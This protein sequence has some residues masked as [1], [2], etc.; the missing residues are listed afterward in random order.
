MA[1]R[2]GAI[3][4]ERVADQFAV[5]DRQAS[6]VSRYAVLVA[7]LTAAG[8]VFRLSDFSQGLFADELSTAWVLGGRSLGQ[9]L[10]VVHSNDEI[11]PPL[12]FVLA[13]LSSKLG[14]NPDLIRLPSLIAGTASIPLV[15]LVGART[16]GRAAGAVA[17][18]VFALSPFMIYYST[19]ARSYA[20]MIAL[21]LC[22]ILALL[23]AL[24]RDGLW[25]WVAFA[26]AAAAAMYSHYTAAFPLAAMGVWALVFHPGRRRNVL[27]A[28]VGAA[29]LFAPWIGG[30]LADARSPTTQI[31]SALSPF[32]F[33]WVRQ[34]IENWAIGFPYV[35]Q[36]SIPGTTAA[37]IALFGVVV[38]V[39]GLA[40]RLLADWR[41]R[42]PPLLAWVRGVPAGW[43]LIVMLAIATPL[44]EAIYSALGPNLLGARN[45]NASWPGLA[46]AIGAVLTAPGGVVSV[47]AIALTLAGFGIGTARTLQDRWARPD[48]QAAADY[49]NSHAGPG[50]VVVDDSA[51]TPVPLTG[52]DVYLHPGHP[53]VRLGLP[54]ETD[55]P[56][57]ILDPVP[58]L[59]DQVREA[60]AAARGHRMF[61]VSART[62]NLVQPIRY[63]FEGLG[64]KLRADLP[65]GYRI[66]RIR[67]YPGLMPLEMDVVYPPEKGAGH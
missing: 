44:G 66:R 30:Y 38:G 39:A 12:F 35:Q 28:G 59:G 60:T 62:P 17:A 32:T 43:A 4:N 10:T 1:S 7:G 54:E 2:E 9:V 20:L 40:G 57:A 5:N 61:V 36:A 65:A 16:V 19:E 13:W 23:A 55:R 67:S 8:L 56:F 27:I 21:V 52:L 18:A 34:S 46:L 63:G 49:I 26:V 45:L 14:S 22:A 47:V 58:R 24:E 15:Y 51:L 11:T 31:L 29:I 42:R 41:R 25:A 48:F 50:D 3:L 37:L 33:A 64:K 6:R 53:E